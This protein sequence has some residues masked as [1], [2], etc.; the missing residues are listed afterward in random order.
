[1][2]TVALPFLVAVSLVGGCATPVE[3]SEVTPKLYSSAEKYV[4]L[5]VIEARP[6]VVTGVRTPKFEGVFRGPFG[7]PHALNRPNRPASERFVDLLAG[8]VKE[9]LAEAGVNVTVVPMPVAASLEDAWKSM[10]QTSAARYIVIR[11]LESNWDAGGIS[12]NFSY[13]YDFGV[14]IA[15]PGGSKQQGKHFSAQ[16]AN[17]ASSKYNIWDMH[18]VRYR[19]IIESMF[20]DPLVRAALQD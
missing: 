3:K 12:G 6:Y 16:E 20:S 14:F 18:S 9:G 11:V 2:R 1:M 7:I 10:S 19:Q 13:K 5:S 4:A 15:G 17:P 8:M